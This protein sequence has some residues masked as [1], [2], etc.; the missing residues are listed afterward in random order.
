MHNISEKGFS[1]AGSSRLPL[2]Y[3]LTQ[4]FSFGAN[5]QSEVCTAPCLCGPGGYSDDFDSASYR[6]R[7]T[8]RCILSISTMIVDIDVMYSIIVLLLLLLQQSHCNCKI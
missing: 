4:P 8:C 2:G 3:V 5:S 7:Y 1:F 6:Y